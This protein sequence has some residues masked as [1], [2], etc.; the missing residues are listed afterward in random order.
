MNCSK[1]NK[2]IEK[3]VMFLLKFSTVLSYDDAWVFLN[4]ILLLSVKVSGARLVDDTARIRNRQE[5][6]N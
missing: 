2:S 6:K 5:E 3:D 4:C 1:I